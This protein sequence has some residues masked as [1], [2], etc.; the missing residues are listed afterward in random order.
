M[1]VPTI[2]TEIMAHSMLDV[3][4]WR[5]MLAAGLFNMDVCSRISAGGEYCNI[6]TV[7]RA[8]DFARQA[9]QSVAAASH[10]AASTTDDKAVV[11]HAI[12]PNKYYK[13]QLDQSNAKQ[14]DSQLSVSVGHKTAKRLAQMTLKCADGAIDAMDT[15]S[16][17]C[18]TKD[19]SSGAMTVN[20]LRQARGLMGDES[21]ELTTLVMHSKVW[22]DLLYDLYTNYKVDTIAGVVIAQAKLRT[23]LGVG[24]LIVTDLCPSAAGATSSAGDDIY[25][26]FLFGPG[27]LA[28]AYQTSPT[29]EVEVNTTNEDSIVYLKTVMAYL[30]HVLG[31]K[32]ASTAN[33][34]DANFTTASNWD[35]AYQDHREVKAVKI[36]SLGGV[37]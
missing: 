18:H 16:T 12:S 27:S 35:E 9:L 19:G 1:Y 29:P 26:S 2:Q 3:R 14:L 15:P 24:N 4:P 21:E 36:K 20:L 22:D 8:A 34:T 6:P 7:N 28:F 30:T 17:N 32:W 5:E 10:T 33:P 25:S 11:L 23:I 37:Y 13:S 31:I